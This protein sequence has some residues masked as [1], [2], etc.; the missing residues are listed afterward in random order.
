MTNRQI[1]K[2]N[3]I[4]FACIHFVVEFVLS[5]DSGNVHHNVAAPV[6]FQYLISWWIIK[7]KI[8]QKS[9]EELIRYTWLVSIC[10][11]TVRIIL[12]IV[13]FALM[14]SSVQ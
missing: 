1:V 8:E 4:I 5:V 12:G 7:G 6:V 9:K 13:L 3:L 2:W 14:L 10:V 11:L